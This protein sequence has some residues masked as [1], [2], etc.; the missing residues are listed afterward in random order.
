MYIINVDLFDF[1]GFK[2]R[3]KVFLVWFVLL[4][5][6]KVNGLLFWLKNIRLGL[7]VF[8]LWL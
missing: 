5:G 7:F 3:L 2:I 4:S 6:L 8:L 1:G